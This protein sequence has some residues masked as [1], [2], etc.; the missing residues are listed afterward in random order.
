M[1]ARVVRLAALPVLL[2]LLAPLYV[3]P[4]GS[5]GFWEPWETDIASLAWLV[6]TDDTQSIFAP[7]RDG[8]FVARP[9]LETALAVLGYRLGEGDELW[10]RLPFA[11]LHLA[12]L[13]FAWLLLERTFGAVRAFFATLLTGLAPAVLLG[14]FHLAGDATA[15]APLALCL[16]SATYAAR[17]A[18]P[19][20]RPALLVFAG[21]ALGFCAW[22]MGIAGV[23]IALGTLGLTAVG[24]R[25]NDLSEKEGRLLF[26]FRV[27]GGV[28]AMV[29]VLWPVLN[30]WVTGLDLAEGEG[31]LSAT[32]AA[33]WSVWKELA[34][35]WIAVG[36][37]AGLLL[38]A[39]P[40]SG[41]RRLWHPVATPVGLLL[42]L[43]L[44]ALPLARISAVLEPVGDEDAWALPFLVHQSILTERVLPDH[45]TFDVLIRIAA[46]GIYPTVML[47]PFAFGYL[48]RTSEPAFE[49]TDDTGEDARLVKHT[50]LLWAG[51][52]F[53]IGGLAA[54]LA[55]QVSFPIALPVC[56]AAALA[57]TDRRFMAWLLERPAVRYAAGFTAIFLLLVLSKDI[58]GT[59]NEE[60]GRPG[61]H[62]LF[63]SLL[64]DGK[65]QFPD[66]Y[67]F[68]RT[69]AFVGLWLL[70]LVVAFLP[71][72]RWLRSAL[73][74]ADAA[75]PEG[76]MGRWVHGSV[77]VPTTRVVVRLDDALTQ[78]TSRVPAGVLPLV[79]LSATIWAWSAQLAFVD[80]PRVTH[81]F[82]QKGLI[83]TYERFAREGE[84][85]WTVG[86]AGGNATYYLR[87]E[88]VERRA[89]V[90][91]I[92]DLFCDAQA[93]ERRVFA[94]IRADALPEAYQAL[95]ETTREG[96]AFADV[97]VLDGR[98]SRYLLLSNELHEDRGEV[99]ESVIAANVFTDETLP[100]DVV[101]PEV[102]TVV[103][104]RIE[105]AGS[106]LRT[107]EGGKW[108]EVTTYWRVLDRPRHAY[109]SFIHVDFGGNRL[110]GDHDLVEG[111]FPMN[112]WVRGDIVRD[113][114]QIK[115][116]R[117]DRA[118]EYTVYY[119][120][121]RGDDRLRVT[122]PTIRD[123]RID[124]GRIAL[125]R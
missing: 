69:S 82:S 9:W 76:R 31:G 114:Y 104:G 60:L 121:F 116:S 83:D 10:F 32:M 38:A 30:V 34:A 124:L 14:S 62:V 53:V 11:L 29:A 122:E 117:A 105:L 46:F 107:L 110:N 74:D 81:H 120:F 54:T 16:L 51:L 20:L 52:A 91:D 24:V 103:D 50:L 7:V 61:P 96:C 118:G 112:R 102:R 84:G 108:L 79:F 4:A 88:R 44:V 48:V 99:Q 28:V 106:S 101:R 26:P 66:S 71:P 55:K 19:L 35:V 13:G 78:R 63:E 95:R 119:G 92:V 123:N 22:G 58:R 89:R 2:L 57:L 64:L 59:F 8:A 97:P 36:V 33:G 3:F 94:V 93:E 43:L 125:G 42:A 109:K 6:A 73:P 47:V 23:A 72:L 37:P 98:S 75:A 40:G 27:A 68:G 65:V 39:V 111:S 113:V 1:N 85:L 5:L 25:A 77:L 80:T 56:T 70:G 12:T 21:A 49:A 41:L 115:V 87:D 86:W 15:F 45:V 100:E 67:A 17:S 18:S 90:S